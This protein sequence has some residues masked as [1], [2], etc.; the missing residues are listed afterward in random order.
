MIMMKYTF[1]VEE[2]TIKLMMIMIPYKQY[3]LP[4]PAFMEEVRE[5][6]KENVEVIAVFYDEIF[7]LH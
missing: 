4:L 3:H 1:L 7:D 5:G 6:E 2:R